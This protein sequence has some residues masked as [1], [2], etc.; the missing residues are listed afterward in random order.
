MGMVIAE[1]DVAVVV[2]PTRITPLHPEGK[3]PLTHLIIAPKQHYVN[4][5]EL[6]EQTQDE[7]RNFQKSL[8]A[9]YRE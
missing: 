4:C 6:D 2:Y 7:M 8:V 1:S 9:F 3:E 5:L